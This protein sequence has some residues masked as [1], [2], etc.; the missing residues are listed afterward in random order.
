M[1]FRKATERR[2]G[3]DQIDIFCVAAFDILEQRYAS[4]KNVIDLALAQ[5]R[6][7]TC[8]GFDEDIWIHEDLLRIYGIEHNGIAND[9]AD[10]H[11]RW[12]I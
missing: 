4:N 6:E 10:I 5:Q 7:K 9:F 1:Q 2:D 3:H 8:D 12:S 11:L